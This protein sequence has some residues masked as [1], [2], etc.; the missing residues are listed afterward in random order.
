MCS[1]VG[2][3]SKKVDRRGLDRKPWLSKDVI[4]VT[5]K[6]L[7]FHWCVIRYLWIHQFKD[8]WTNRLSCIPL[9]FEFIKIEVAFSKYKFLSFVCLIKMTYP[10]PLFIYLNL[11][12]HVENVEN[13]NNK[14]EVH[15][16]NHLPPKITKTLINSL[17]SI[18]I[19]I[20]YFSELK[21]PPEHCSQN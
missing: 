1:I 3:F 18:A 14:D 13:S 11:Q 7:F 5:K 15:N 2:L 20:I 12:W 10:Y 9:K 8:Q 16:C 19:Y 4:K 21:L 17:K 6:C